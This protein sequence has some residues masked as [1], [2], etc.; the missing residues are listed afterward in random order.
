MSKPTTNAKEV[1]EAIISEG[2]TPSER[3][4]TIETDDGFYNIRMEHGYPFLQHFYVPPEKRSINDSASARRLIKTVIEHVRSLGYSK[5]IISAPNERFD[6]LIS[7]YF[8]ARPYTRQ[9]EH[10]F[11]LVEVQHGR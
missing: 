6:K 2:F 4:E 10:N 3:G 1:R 8:K 7:Y 9:D 11:Y 5:M